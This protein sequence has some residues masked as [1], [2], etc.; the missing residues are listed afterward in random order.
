MPHSPRST[1]KIATPSCSRGG[2]RF[3]HDSIK[4]NCSSYKRPPDSDKRKEISAVTGVTHCLRGANFGCKD[5]N[6]DCRDA[7][8]GCKDANF[9]CRDVN[10]GC[11]DANFGCKD[12]N[13]GCKDAN[14]GCRDAIFGCRDFGCTDAIF[15]RG[16]ENLLPESGDFGLRSFNLNIV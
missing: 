6:F 8:R 16:I 11:R 13:F 12:A 15:I 14:F 1:C 9:G 3:R 2:E 10:F 7:N 5:A 4:P